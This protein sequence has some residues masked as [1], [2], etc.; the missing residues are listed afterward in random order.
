M[1]SLHQLIFYE[2]CER[3]SQLHDPMPDNEHETRYETEQLVRMVGLKQRG[4]ATF[5]LHS[6]NCIVFFFWGETC[7]KMVEHEEV[8]ASWV[9]EDASDTARNVSS[10]A[11]F[12][13]RSAEF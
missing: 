10:L 9:A 8:N 7:N 3:C 12:A 11:R 6:Q 5:Q 13:K 1:R 2:G 4:Q